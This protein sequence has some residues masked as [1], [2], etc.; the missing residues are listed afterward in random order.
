MH[1]VAALPREYLIPD[2]SAI[3]AAVRQLKGAT[4]IPG[5][6]VWQDERVIRRG[7]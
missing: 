6:R 2:R 5:V 1:V 4:Q 7:A 3:G